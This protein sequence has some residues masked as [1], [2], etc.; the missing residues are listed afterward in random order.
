MTEKDAERQKDRHSERETETERD[1]HTH[2]NT[3]REKFTNPP[4]KLREDPRPEGVSSAVEGVGPKHQ[5]YR[6]PRGQ[7]ERKGPERG[8][9]TISMANKRP[10]H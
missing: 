10:W 4:T 1:R 8:L 7:S 5:D 6:E 2:R 3:Q 9:Q